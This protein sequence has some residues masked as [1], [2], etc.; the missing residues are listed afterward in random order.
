MILIIGGSKGLGKEISKR[1]SVSKKVIAIARSVNNEEI[2]NI[3]YIKYDVNQPNE[4]ILDENLVNKK[5]DAVFFTVGLMDIKDEIA[6]EDTISHNILNTNFLSITRF[7][8][9]LLNQN[10]LNDNSLLCFC[11]SVTTFL[12]RDKNVFYSSSKVSLNNYVRSL[13]YFFLKNNYNVRVVNL[14]L[15]Y[16]SSN[17]MEENN[18]TPLLRS[19]STKSLAEKIFKNYKNMGGE[20]IYPKYWVLIKFIIFFMPKKLIIFIIKKLKV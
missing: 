8:S 10:K 11:S 4:K 7:V 5:F 15:G 20:I 13:E 18:K 14:I 19:L 6:C 2:N 3:K 16:L 9:Y 1:F 12:P 17:M